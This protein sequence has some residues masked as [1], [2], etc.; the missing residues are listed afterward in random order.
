[1]SEFCQIGHYHI[2]ILECVNG[3]FYATNNDYCHPERSEG[4]SLLEDSSRCS[5]GQR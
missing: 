1:M 5:E 3:Y 4:S 2:K